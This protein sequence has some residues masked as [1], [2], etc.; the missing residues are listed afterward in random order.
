MKEKNNNDKIQNYYTAINC[1][2]VPEGSE[3]MALNVRDVYV[4]YFK[5]KQ[6]FVSSTFY[7]SRNSENKFNYINMVVW[8]SYESASAV[9]NEGFNNEDGLNEDNMK[10]L[11]KGFPSPI[12]VSPGQYTIIRN[13]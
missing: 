11:G 9:I 13:D 6:G 8:D 10:V 2:E 4:N 7:K 3:E 1:I 5:Q 12:K